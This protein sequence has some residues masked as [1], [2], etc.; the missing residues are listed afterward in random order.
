MDY[1]IWIFLW[2]VLPCQLHSHKT[3]PYDILFLI[4]QGEA[5]IMGVIFQ[6]KISVYARTANMLRKSLDEISEQFPRDVPKE[7][8]IFDDQIIEKSK[9]FKFHSI[10]NLQ[11]SFSELLSAFEFV[12][13]LQKSENLEKSLGGTRAPQR[14]PVAL[15]SSDKF[16]G[17]IGTG[18][19][20]PGKSSM[21]N[22]PPRA[23]TPSAS[24][25]PSE[26]SANGMA[27]LFSGKKNVP[28]SKE[29]WAFHPDLA[30]GGFAFVQHPF[31]QDSPK[32]CRI[33]SVGK[34]GVS[35]KDIDNIIRNIRW[36]HIHDIKS[37][38]HD[39]HVGG[40]H[41]EAMLELGRMGM[42]NEPQQLTSRQ[43]IEAEDLLRDMKAP[44]ESDLITDTHPDRDDAYQNLIEIG[45]P[46]DA[47]SATRKTKAAL[48]DLPDYMSDLL[49]QAQQKGAPLDVD[50]LANFSKKDILAVLK[51]Y[52][53]EDAQKDESE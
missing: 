37:P 33:V 3:F 39:K 4:L 31:D 44:L 22:G 46:L 12:D 36:E 8:T 26:Q 17:H 7:Y 10:E 18:M 49:L 16:I 21:R 43:L 30:E 23:T 40:D 9:A 13:H 5:T 38:V 2:I 35:A 32:W 11:G 1:N 29:N 15:P 53:K 52:F 51:Y 27:A 25:P 45:A 48:D 14:R 28:V 20:P 50:K 6:K 34:H 19:R 47:I 24:V 41:R 42:P